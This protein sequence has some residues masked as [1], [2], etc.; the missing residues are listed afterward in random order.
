MDE[1]VNR[2][3]PIPKAAMTEKTRVLGSKSM[4]GN[5]IYQSRSSTR[6]R[7]SWSTD[8]P[9]WRGPLYIRCDF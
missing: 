4:L 3:G 5:Y 2:S 9:R 8:V 1:G 6:Q 7:Q